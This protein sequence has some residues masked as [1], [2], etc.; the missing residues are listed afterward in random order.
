[1]STRNTKPTALKLLSG[2]A[3]GLD[4]G[5]RPVPEDAYA[6]RLGLD[7]PIPFHVAED[8]LAR[9]EWE[10]VTPSLTSLN[11]TKPEDAQT[12]ALYCTAVAVY[13][14]ATTALREEGL[15]IMTLVGL[16]DGSTQE[17][18]IPNPHWRIVKESGEQLLRFAK[19][20]GLT[21]VASAHLTKAKL[22]ANGGE[23]DEANN[24]FGAVK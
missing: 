5:G 8:P 2:R 4:S 21:P 19:E 3:P 15:T 20:Y 1:M 11:L 14:R 13:Q 10:R 22:D 16:P 9:A 24:P 17:K 7:M 23:P 6:K 12:F 18:P